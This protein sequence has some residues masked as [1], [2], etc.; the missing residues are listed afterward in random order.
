MTASP[1]KTALRKT[2]G[3]GQFTVADYAEQHGVTRRTALNH[4]NAAVNDGKVSIVGKVETGKR[5]RP[6]HKY[7]V[8]SGK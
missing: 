1:S 5:G 7:K 6:A 8:V 2:V 3:K 4:L